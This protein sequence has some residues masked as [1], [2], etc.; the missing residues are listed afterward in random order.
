MTLSPRRRD[1]GTMQGGP[2]DSEEGGVDSIDV[3]A[4]AEAPLAR[5]AR[6]V[7]E[8]RNEQR[9][10]KDTVLGELEELRMALEK[11]M[12]SVLAQLELK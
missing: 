9:A 4:A 8:V 12:A 2:N 7:G 6:L 1:V 3:V 11:D 10:V 5:A